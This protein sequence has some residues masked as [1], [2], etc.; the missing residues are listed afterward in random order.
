MIKRT[1]NTIT[2]VFLFVTVLLTFTG[3]E[4]GVESLS[5][6][7]YR[8]T[9]ET[10]A[11]QQT[12]S[13]PLRERP[14]VPV[15]EEGRFLSSDGV[16]ATP[17]YE[18]AYKKAEPRE[19]PDSGSEEYTAGSGGGSDFLRIMYRST[20]PVRLELYDDEGN[21]RTVQLPGAADSPAGKEAGEQKGKQVE[22]RIPLYEKRIEA[23]RFSA[24]PAHDLSD[25]S[26]K[27]SSDDV[28]AP[29]FYLDSIYLISGNAGGDFG[30]SFFS[31][32]SEPTIPRP[33]F[34][35]TAYALEYSYIPG[36]IPAGMDEKVQNVVLSLTD[37]TRK[38]PYRL[39]VR[40]GKHT[41]YFYSRDIPFEPQDIYLDESL[42]GFRI[43]K[44]TAQPVSLMVQKVPEPIPADMGTL[45]RYDK[46]AWRRSDYELFSWNL[47]PDILVFDFRDYQLQSAFLKRLSFFVEKKGST[48]RLLP[49]SVIGSLHGWNAHDYRAKDLARF[50]RTAEEEDFQLN[51]EE[52]LLRDILLEQGIIQRKDGSLISGR[53]G[54]L[55]ISRQ[56]SDRLRYLFITHEGYHGLY[57]AS[58][59]YREEVNTI[60]NDLSEDEKEFWRIFLDWKLYEVKDTDLV[61]NEFQAYLMQQHLSYVD[62]YFKDYTI[63]RFVRRYPE[64]SDKAEYFLQRYPNH[65]IDSAGQIQAAA[66]DLAGISAG[67]L[68]CIR[69]SAVTMLK[70]EDQR[71]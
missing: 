13:I 9:Q 54:I 18:I 26:R 65:F 69:E 46:A 56:S 64:Y 34:S 4:R 21:T 25:G 5:L 29:E 59:E 24:A 58:A 20:L 10:A 47:F 35:Q 37:G 51:E 70:S 23:F 71:Y 60:W 66:E 8:K 17:R 49:N 55:S 27:D 62:I 33:R 16:Y 57:F 28:P 12:A 1:I 61:I 7:V 15:E 53:G 42:P 45:L 14:G 40:S 31:P 19:N 22:A 6:E 11:F 36:L 3:C 41:V 2:G 63:P 30:I 38:L 43:E 39:F 44:I 67:D 32:D 68:V 50:F 52:Y 48:G